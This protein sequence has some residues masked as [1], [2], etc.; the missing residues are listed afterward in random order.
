MTL[1]LSIPMP[2]IRGLIV[3][4]PAVDA[5][6]KLRAG[7]YEQAE[8]IEYF[9]SRHDR[10]LLAAGWVAV[11]ADGSMSLTRDGMA[12]A[13]RLDQFGIDPAAPHQPY[14]TVLMLTERDCRSVARSWNNSLFG[15]VVSEL[16]TGLTVYP[17]TLDD[18]LQCRLASIE[19]LLT[20]LRGEG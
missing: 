1:S 11:V 16:L 7:L 5:R 18:A 13:F 9:V 10:V 12:R 6:A 2:D 14:G 8:A 20:V 19:K 3:P 15:R 4:V 17:M